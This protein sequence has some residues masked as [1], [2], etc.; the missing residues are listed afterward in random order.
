MEVDGR[1]RA[2]LYV[3]G[4]PRWEYKFIRRA[5]ESDRALRL[6][7]AVRATPNRYYRQG[8]TSGAELEEGFPTSAAELFKYDAIILGSL[9]AAALSTEQNQWLKEFVSIAAAARC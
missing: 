1:R 7:S 9:E 2:V 6:A 3:E 5:V 8:L 4:E